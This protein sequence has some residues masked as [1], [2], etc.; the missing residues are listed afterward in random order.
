MESGAEGLEGGEYKRERQ[1]GVVVGVGE[2]CAN[3]GC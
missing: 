1:G 3:S 2:N